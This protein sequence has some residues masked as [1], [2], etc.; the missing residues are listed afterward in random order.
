MTKKDYVF[1]FEVKKNNKKIIERLCYCH[2]DIYG[3]IYKSGA[4]NLIRS[5][6][7]VDMFLMITK[8]LSEKYNLHI[9]SDMESIVSLNLYLIIMGKETITNVIDINSCS[10]VWKL[11]KDDDT[12]IYDCKKVFKKYVDNVFRYPQH[13]VFLFSK[14]ELDNLEKDKLNM[15]LQGMSYAIESPLDAIR[16]ISERNQNHNKFA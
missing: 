11:T 4:M 16:I 10:T 6:F 15:L 1:T 5:P 3:C 12:I 7:L 8:N 14:E 9:V 13:H 2:G